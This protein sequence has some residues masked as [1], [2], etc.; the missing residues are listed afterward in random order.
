MIEIT[1]T[2]C[3]FDELSPDVKSDVICDIVEKIILAASDDSMLCFVS[4]FRKH[5]EWIMKEARS[6]YY[7]KNGNKLHRKG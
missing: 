3:E 5:Q 1:V 2:A 6:F 4:T 7:D